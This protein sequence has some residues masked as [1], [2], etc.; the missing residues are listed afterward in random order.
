[1]TEEQT[2]RTLA[3]LERERAGYQGRHDA[4]ASDEDRVR[5]R[6]RISGVDAEIQRLRPAAIT[7]PRR[8]HETRSA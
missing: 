5:L 3:A 7:R 2:A 1:M 4:A 6:D 8:A